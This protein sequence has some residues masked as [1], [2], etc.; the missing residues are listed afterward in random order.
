MRWAK[1]KNKLFCYLKCTLFKI[2]MI[3][4]K[5]LKWIVFLHWSE[6]SSTKMTS[7][8]RWLG[9]LSITECTV[10]NRVDHASLWKQII[11]LE[12]G[13]FSRNLPGSLHLLVNRWKIVMIKGVDMCN[14][15]KKQL[16]QKTTCYWFSNLPLIPGVRQWPV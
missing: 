4:N 9:D 2:I 11:T 5:R 14:F 10:L 6:A 16:K 15:L 3:S 12:E 7:F 1:I 13:R 8:N